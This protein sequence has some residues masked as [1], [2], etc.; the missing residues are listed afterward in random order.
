M[1]TN[2]TTTPFPEFTLLEVKKHDGYIYDITKFIGE[3]PGG[4]EITLDHLGTDASS[5]FINPAV[6]EHSAAA[7]RMLDEYKVGILK[8][9]VV[10]NRLTQKNEMQEI[11]DITKPIIPQIPKLGDKYQEWIHSQCGLK[12]IIIFDSFLEMFTRWPW[13]YIFI[14]W[15]PFIYYMLK[16]GA[17]STSLSVNVSMFI[18]GLLSFS[19]VEYILHRFVFHL[20]SKTTFWNY[21]HFFAHG[22]HHLTPNDSTRLTFPPTFSAVI[23]F[24]IFQ[25]PGNVFP[26]EIGPHAFL[27]GLATGFVMYDTAHYYF[28]HG[29]AT[30]LPT[31]L[32]RMKTTHL[33]HHYKDDTANFGVTSPLFDWVFGTLS[34]SAPQAA[35]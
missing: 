4:K 20:S 14:L 12:K 31:F 29:D 7:Y 23:A 18:V 35:S 21:F 22:I 1:E 13:H 33:N 16:Q 25:L 17:A 28:H 30:W 3:H 2:I 19:I 9:A 26:V 10:V 32:Q 34:K 6:H 24:G 15:S 11:V 27:A 5:I 8:S